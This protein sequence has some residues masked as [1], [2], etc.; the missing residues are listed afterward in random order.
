MKTEVELH[1]VFGASGAIGNAVVREL[2]RR[3]KAVRAVNRSGQAELPPG[4]TLVRAN[5]VNAGMVREACQGASVVYNCVGVPYTEWATLFPPIMAGL[6][7]GAA[8]AGAKLIFADNLYCYGPAAGPMT[9]DLPYRPTTTKGKVRAQLAET[10]ME[11][12]SAGRVRAAIGRASDYYGPG[13]VASVTGADLFR[14]VLAGKQ[15]MWT[16]SLDMQ[17]SLSYIED[18]ARGLVTLG[19]RDEA[20]GQVWHLPCAEPLTGRQF[21]Q[22]AFEVAGRPAKIGSYGRLSL[23]MAGLFIPLAREVIEMLYEFDAPFVMNADKF[24]RAFGPSPATPHH[25]AVRQTIEWHQ[26]HPR[27]ATA[28][29]QRAAVRTAVG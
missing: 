18:V 28:R 10:L 7:E 3:G 26:A 21:V 25:E 4:V 14:S 22:L 24:N 19:E 27:A 12:H 11:A 8:A 2:A 29:T 9:E 15:A 6:I 17:H 13:V 16:G 1:V 20:L 23:T 5:A